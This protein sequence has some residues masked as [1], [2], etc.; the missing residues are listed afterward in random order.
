MAQ[1]VRTTI[2]RKEVFWYKKDDWVAQGQIIASSGN[3]G[4]SSAP[5][6]RFD[7]RAYWNS[8]SDS[9]PKIP[10]IF[11]DKNHTAWRPKVGDML[12]SNNTVLNF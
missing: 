7:T 6:V 2:L 11:E 8:P 10:V 4:N 5:H 3:T 1:L 9:G 12:A